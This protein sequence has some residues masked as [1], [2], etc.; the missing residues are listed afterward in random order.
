M[1]NSITKNAIP[2]DRDPDK[3][4][5]PLGKLM[6]IK[7]VFTP[8]YREKITPRLAL[9]LYK[10]CAAIE[11]EERF[12]GDRLNKIITEFGR[13]DASGNPEQDDE[14]RIKI[15]AGQE[16]ACRAAKDE[17]DNM[18]VDKPDISFDIDELSE[19]KLSVLDLSL[20][21]DFIKD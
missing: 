12:Y 21:V 4:K 9:K 1:D 17:L 13:K 8:L 11:V 20:L 19:I 15:I 2:A 5:I 14:G 16:Q 7:N 18:L 10:F 3:Q 6:R